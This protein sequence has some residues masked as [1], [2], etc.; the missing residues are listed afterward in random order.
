MICIP[1]DH[2]KI[3]IWAKFNPLDPGSNYIYV[4]SDEEEVEE[5][6]MSVAFRYENKDDGE[7]TF[8]LKSNKSEWQEYNDER[9]DDL[10]DCLDT[11]RWKKE[12]LIE[13]L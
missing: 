7:R 4:S 1:K 8:F 10:L 9:S 13:L 3:D 5:D 2:L 11:S 12:L 6:D